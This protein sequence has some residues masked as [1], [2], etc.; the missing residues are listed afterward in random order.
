M[1]KDQT[2]THLLKAKLLYI[3]EKIEKHK[4][5]NSLLDALQVLLIWGI[6]FILIEHVVYLP[7]EIKSGSIVGVIIL[8]SLV[9]WKKKRSIKS[10]NFIDFYRRFSSVSNLKELS[11]ALDLER[12]TLAHPK[13]IEA[14]IFKNLELVKL[15]Q[16]NSKLNEF[17]HSNP[18]TQSLAKKGVF[19]LLLVGANILTALNFNDA[20]IRYLT[21]YQDFKKPNPYSFNIT[22][23]N[24]TLE[25]GSPFNVTIEFTTDLLPK[26]VSL[27]LKTPVEQ[28][29]RKR[30]LDGQL[31]TFIYSTIDL[32]SDILYYL[33]M[34]GFKTEIFEI[35]VQLRP[36]LTEFNLAI[37]PPRYTGLDSSLYEYPFSQVQGIQGSEMVLSGKANKPLK[38]FLIINKEVEQ[39][40]SINEHL[41]FN[42]LSSLIELDT[43]K[44][45][46]KDEAGLKNLNPFQFLVFPIEDEYPVAEI[47]EPSSSFEEI[48]P[49]TISIRYR[50]S[51]DFGITKTTL[52]YELKRAFVEQ[53]IRNSI[54][55]TSNIN[56]ILQT[57]SFDIDSLK[58]KPKDELTF[59]IETTDND[60]FNGYKTARSV[61]ITL[62][63]PSLVDYFDEIGVQEEEIQSDLENVSE[64][65][66]E[67][68]R[69]YEMFE[70]QMRDNPTVDYKDIRQL[71]EVKQRQEQVKEQLEELNAKFEE[72]KKELQ[73]SDL[74]SEET[75][76]AYNE[77]QKLMDEIDDPA[78]REA[79]QELQEN[80][81]SMTPEQ[82][83]EA[84]Q[85]TEFNE[86]LYKER[87]ERTIELFKKLKLNADLEKLATSYE[88]MARQE[89]ESEAEKNEDESLLEQTEQLEKK[90]EKL[91]EN[92]SSSTESIINELQKQS[93]DKL[94]EIKKALEKRLEES[95]NEQSDNDSS[96]EDN[97]GEK[98]SE[99][100][101]D[102]GSKPQQEQN[103][104]EQF[105]Q[106]AQ[107]TRNA[108][109]QMNQDQM[110]VNIAGLQYI[111]YSLLNLSLEQEELSM[112][113]SSTESR[114]QAYVG[115]AREQKNVENIFSS[116]SD[117]L[118]E[119][120]KDIPPFSNQINEDKLEVERLVKESLTQIAERNQNRASVATRQALGGINKISYKLA[121]LLEQLQNQNSGQGGSGSGMSMQQMIEQMQQMGENQQ[122]I[123][124]Q[125]QDMINDIQ[126]ERLSQDQM[127]R[128]D[129]LSKQQ[130]NIRKQLQD[131][132]KNGSDLEGDKLGSE[133]ERMIEQMEETINDLRG[134][135]IDPTLIRRQQNILSRMLQAENA[136]QERDEEEKR[137]G[138]SGEQVN[139]ATPPEITLE[140][141]EQQIRNRLNDPNFTKY[142]PDYQRL[143]E[144]Y[145]ELLKEIQEREI[146]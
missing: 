2:S 119:L 30:G 70:E 34:D 92:T 21:F 51:D 1:S 74:L 57:F 4:S 99:E 94:D 64:S 102:N 77:L 117:S 71:E 35:N 45:K 44:F 132:Q 113:T 25:Q 124:Q 12:N 61:S 130:N 36:R 125:I 33:E 50:T 116:L 41:E 48:E 8:C 46:L 29:F 137:E 89:E 59:W 141:L 68:Q 127:E 136:L 123:N 85:K 75:L 146:Q 60:G 139:R 105:Q 17:Y 31:N 14:A 110:N 128:L 88:D 78:F 11:Y 103:L 121:G 47:I 133:L 98:Q 63:I 114:S 90:L 15:E 93:K 120:S 67:M 142:S 42:F 10:T 126:G 72:L 3:Y 138:T 131:L 101:E 144:R 43:L 129:Q 55:F 22:P 37:I 27:F 19:L 115:Y 87:I 73:E 91:D 69:Q 140:E 81:N 53:T 145:F 80:L 100:S 26:E 16:F 76:D 32:N 86:Q 95:N 54:R 28:E 66:E 13:L 108:M 58:L 23:G 122:Q 82:M 143:I 65:F 9:Y 83:R 118:F 84:M 96:N 18:F 52:V 20:T 107:M 38:E 112:Y 111:L 56:G 97:K 5:Y 62:S 106:L 7:I 49:K 24:S 40:I 134:G 104:K 6:V 39:G 79:L 135:A 109:S